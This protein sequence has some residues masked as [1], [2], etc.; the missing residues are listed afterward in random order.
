MISCEHKTP[1][2]QHRKQKMSFN[3]DE[4]YQSALDFHTTEDR[5][6]SHPQRATES[7]LR[8]PWGRFNRRTCLIATLIAAVVCV[9]TASVAGLVIYRSVTS[10]WPTDP[11]ERAIFV[12]STQQPIIDGHNDLPM[13][14][15]GIFYRLMRMEKTL[16]REKYEQNRDFVHSHLFRLNETMSKENMEYLERE[17]GFTLHTDIPRMVQGRLRA[18]FWSIYT[19][20]EYQPI[21]ANHSILEQTLEQF[22]TIDQMVRLYPDNLIMV[23][24]AD[25]IM[26]VF[27]RPRKPDAVA[28]LI[29]LEGG[30]MIENSLSLLRT[31]YRSGVR[32]MT[33]T[34]SCS[35]D[36]AASSTIEPE[37]D[38]GLTDFGHEVVREMNHLG[39]L[40][41][42]SHVS[43]KTMHDAIDTSVAPV[44]FSHSGARAVCSHPRNVPDDVLLRLKTNGGVAMVNYYPVFVSETEHKKYN[45]LYDQ[46]QDD[47]IAMKMLKEWELA[48]PDLRASLKD[49]VDHIDHIR[50]VTGSCDHIGIGK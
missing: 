37:K 9:I 26:D 20:C 11:L 18:Q 32:Y 17:F 50:N 5:Q 44:I 23:N 41:D 25:E 12:S 39:M 10:R 31:Y 42:L 1:P 19:P 13:R 38:F 24:A 14:I 45:E 16:P 47:G 15:R 7:L 4:E 35:L 29:G 2:Q 46:Y 34:H 22:D 36:W 3:R 27:R 21:K 30:H 48:N 40:V 43:P 49:V 28:S 6:Y 8:K 33:L